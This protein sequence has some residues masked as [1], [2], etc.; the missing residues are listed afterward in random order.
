[1]NA[2]S[3]TSAG[4][5]VHDGRSRTMRGGGDER[6]D[7]RLLFVSFAVKGAGVVDTKNWTV[8]IKP[9]TV[10]KGDSTDAKTSYLQTRIQSP[11]GLATS[12]RG[13]IRRPDLPR[14]QAL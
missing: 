2:E 7:N 9:N 6:G 1:V 8:W 4:F 10:Q 14:T 3:G 13:E 11:R 5:G 12:L